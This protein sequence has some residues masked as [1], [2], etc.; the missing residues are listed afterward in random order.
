MDA[1]LLILL[2]IVG[3]SA[4]LMDAAVGGGGL[5][6]IPALFNILPTTTPTSTL[7]I[8]KFASSL[9]TLNATAHFARKISLPWKML[10]PAA[11]GAFTTSYTGA[12]L[13]TWLPIQY[14][15][16]MMLLIMVTMFIYTFTKK[17]L[18]QH[19]RQNQLSQRE[20]YTGIVYCSLIGLY[21]GI[22]GPGTGSL[23]A[24]VFV[25]FFSYDF[26]TATASAKVINLITN[27]AALSFF[28]PHGHIIW[29]WAIPLAIANFCGGFAGSWLAIKY[30]TQFLRIG[31][32]GLLIVLISKF[33]Y[34][35]WINFPT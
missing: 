35:T 14:I 25:R 9:G 19:I 4:G 26:L 34:D 32:M 29:L 27:L 13:T 33:G 23:L 24:F 11:I 6:Q 17:N 2:I 18:G 10:I 8:N 3:F 30:G 28:I 1:S 20:Y 15:K 12:Q 31:F 5:L 21:D 7:G 22:F 16:P